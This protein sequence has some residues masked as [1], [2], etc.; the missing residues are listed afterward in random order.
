MEKS[1]EHLSAKSSIPI[2]HDPTQF[3]NEGKTIIFEI[4]IIS[5]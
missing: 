5:P 2:I 1:P 4:Q 3:G